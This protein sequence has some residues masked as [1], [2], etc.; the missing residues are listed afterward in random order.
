MTNRVLNTVAG[1]LS[2]RAPQRESLEALQRA[3]A[4][5]PDMLHPKRDTAFMLDI[6]NLNFPS[7]RILNA[8]FHHCVLRWQ[9]ESVKP[10]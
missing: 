4:A 2:L 9:P 7:Y 1:R 3:I 8:S 6:Q 10:A 5:T